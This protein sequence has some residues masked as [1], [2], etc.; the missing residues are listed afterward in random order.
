M[1][2]ILTHAVAGAA[3]AQV[4]APCSLRR[5]VTWIAAAC[6]MLPDADVLR[7]RSGRSL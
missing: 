4:L 5:E 1:P 6:A 3:I 7:V 2:T